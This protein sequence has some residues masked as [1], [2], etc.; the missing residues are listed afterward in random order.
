MF[1]RKTMNYPTTCPTL[2]FSR[3]WIIPD[4]LPF[5]PSPS[6]GR[7]KILHD[8][9]PFLSRIPLRSL[10]GAVCQQFQRKFCYCCCRLLNSPGIWWYL[11]H[12][13]QFWLRIGCL[14]PCLAKTHKDQL[15]PVFKFAASCRTPWDLKEVAILCWIN[16]F[17]LLIVLPPI[18]P[19]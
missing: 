6:I 4:I 15:L 18:D 8:K 17:L 9:R 16:L 19:L 10:N 1:P 14:C 7:L 11:Q 12:L 5:D 13:Y 3:I 2:L